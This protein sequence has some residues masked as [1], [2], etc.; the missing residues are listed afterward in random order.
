MLNQLAMAG[1]FLGVPL[2]D[3]AALYR[4]REQSLGIWLKRLIEAAKNRAVQ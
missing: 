2:E 3:L 1:F 4:G